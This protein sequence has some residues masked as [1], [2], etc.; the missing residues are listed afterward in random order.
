ME[1]DYDI[2]NSVVVENLSLNDSIALNDD[3]KLPLFGLGTYSITDDSLSDKV[4]GRA[5]ELGYR[6][7]DTAQYYKNEK[8]VGRAI[9]ASGYDREDFYITT[10][11]WNTN[12]GSNQARENINRSFELL[13]LEY[14]DLFLVHWP[15]ADK[16][17]ETW[18][19]LEELVESDMIKTIG[20]SNY[21]VSHLEELLA[22]SDV[23]PAVNQIDFSPF[24][25]QDDTRR[26]CKEYKIA[27]QG[28]SPL[29]VGKQLD[30]T[31]VN[32]IAKKHNKS[33]AQVYLRWAIQHEVSTIPRTSSDKHLQENIDIYD[34]YLDA[35]DMA[36][37]K[38]LNK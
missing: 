2:D 31:V 26:F 22:N 8:Q 14:I 27:I 9:R 28:Y 17:L 25:Q 6:L 30:N 20:V 1:K 18:R 35:E 15:V 16:H 11:V 3:T 7:F 36:Q 19:V 10:K 38:A 29:T 13:G 21:K 4:F 5:I 23:T 33:S 34:F 32:G 24:L 12:E 37:L